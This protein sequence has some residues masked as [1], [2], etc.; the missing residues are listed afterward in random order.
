MKTTRRN[1]SQI[2]AEIRALK[3]N[4]SNYYEEVVRADPYTMVA[5]HMV[6]KLP[7]TEIFKDMSFKDIRAYCKGPTMTY[8]YNSRAEPIKAFGKDTQELQA[9]YDTLTELFPG[10]INV[11]EALND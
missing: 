7:H 1:K 11:M 5:E 10:A 6:N 9:F 8:F 3:S 2:L 4:P